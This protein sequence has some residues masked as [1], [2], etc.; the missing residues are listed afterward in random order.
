MAS[1]VCSSLWGASLLWVQPAYS[2]A[3]G[4]RPLLRYIIRLPYGITNLKGSNGRPSEIY[5][6]GVSGR[7]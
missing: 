4:L 1:W 2:A 3:M 7:S 6:K 5:R